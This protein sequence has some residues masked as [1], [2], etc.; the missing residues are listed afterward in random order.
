MGLFAKKNIRNLRTGRGGNWSLPGTH[1][2]I[3]TRIENKEEGFKGHSVI[4]EYEIV[5]SDNPD[6]KEGDQRSWAN[7]ITKHGDMALGNIADFIRAALQTLAAEA[8]VL[9]ETPEEI[10]EFDETDEARIIPDP[11]SE[12]TSEIIGHRMKLYCFVKKTA[13]K[14]E[15]FTVH[16]W[17]APDDLIETLKAAA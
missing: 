10:D 12:T 2:V 17:A 4:I 11:D 15:D 16:N 5:S 6:L 7:N 3:I 9:Y 14:K 1:E 8:E 13:G